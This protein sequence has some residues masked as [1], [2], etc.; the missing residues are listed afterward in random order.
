MSAYHMPGSSL[1]ALHILTCIIVPTAYKVDATA[2]LPFYAKE[3][4]ETGSWRGRGLRNFPR[5]TQVAESEFEPQGIQ[6]QN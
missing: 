4:T 6:L 5:D 2:I 1:S 3:E